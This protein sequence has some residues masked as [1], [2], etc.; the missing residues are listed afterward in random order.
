MAKCFTHGNLIHEYSINIR[1]HPWSVNKLMYYPD[2][3]VVPSSLT[4]SIYGMPGTDT[5]HIN[6]WFMLISYIQT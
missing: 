5:D 1:N 2:Y 3:N 6:R 4:F